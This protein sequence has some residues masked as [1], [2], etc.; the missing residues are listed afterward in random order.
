[1]GIHL[2]P[3]VRIYYSDLTANNRRIV[4]Q[5][6]RLNDTYNARNTDC[7]CDYWMQIRNTK[8]RQME[9]QIYFQS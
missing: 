6:A 4:T 2:D 7:R 9:T 5:K 3:S 8:D 1:M